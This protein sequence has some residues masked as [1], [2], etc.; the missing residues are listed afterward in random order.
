MIS[1]N[2]KLIRLILLLTIGLVS[3]Q[4]TFE[5]KIKSKLN[6]IKGINL[7]S[8]PKHPWDN[9]LQ[10]KMLICKKDK[11]YH[12]GI[13]VFEFDSSIVL[14]FLNKSTFLFFK[15]QLKD[16]DVSNIEKN[17]FSHWEYGCNL[18][19]NGIFNNY[20]VIN[21]IDKFVQ[22][23][24]NIDSL[25]QTLKNYPESDTI[26]FHKFEETNSEYY[27]KTD[28]SYLTK[29]VDK[30]NNDSSFK[31]EHKNCNCNDRIRF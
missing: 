11:N 14:Y 13:T 10:I 25:V 27:V 5:D 21:S 12:V 1:N 24:E 29:A 19:R 7:Y 26:Y 15:C 20:F 17:Y 30:L 2:Y 8:I 23:I 9:E 16:K 22:Q 3:C 31:F 18:G 28:T 4:P 6:N